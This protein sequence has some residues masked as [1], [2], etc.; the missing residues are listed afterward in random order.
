MFKKNEK[1][2]TWGTSI[3]ALAIGIGLSLA[4]GESLLQVLARLHPVLFTEMIIPDPKQFRF[5]SLFLD[6]YKKNFSRTDY[7]AWT[8]EPYEVHPTRG[9]TTK[10]N[11]KEPYTTNNMGHRS[12]KPYAQDTARFNILA[13]GDSFTFGTG[14]PD[15]QVWPDFLSTNDSRYNVVN[16]GVGGY[17]ID[18]MHI[19]LKESIAI[20]TPDLVILVFIADDLRRSLFYFN[21]YKKPRFIMVG[22]RLVNIS[23]NIGG[24]SETYD[25]ILKK[26]E[27]QAGNFKSG[28]LLPFALRNVYQKILQ[29]L[30]SDEQEYFTLNAR[31]LDETIELCNMHQTDLLVVHIGMG[32][33]LINANLSDK[34]E[35]FLTAFADQREVNILH[36]RPAF[37]AKDGNWKT[38]GHYGPKEHLFLSGLIQAKVQSLA[39]WQ[40]WVQGNNKPTEHRKN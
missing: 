20:Y 29:P 14:A 15:N 33:G 16:L 21:G 5:E 25:E 32:E 22:E 24:L 8:R 4:I 23:P 31:L 3:L 18:Q 39:S 13:I 2:H 19:T 40:E 12:T 11:N 7:F 36:T 6:N 35:I 30:F 27:I 37:L 26:H 17:G 38:S 9:W 28:F 34:G 10:P 1:R